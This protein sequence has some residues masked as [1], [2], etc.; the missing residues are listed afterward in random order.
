ML[1]QRLRAFVRV[2]FLIGFVLPIL[3]ASHAQSFPDVFEIVNLNASADKCEYLREGIIRINYSLNCTGGQGTENR[4][5]IL[6]L[7]DSFNFVDSLGYKPYIKY[8]SGVSPKSANY[9]FE[10]ERGFNMLKVFLYAVNNE[11][12]LIHE[13]KITCNLSP[14]LRCKI[15]RTYDFADSSFIRLIP[16]CSKRGSCEVEIINKVPEVL[17]IWYGK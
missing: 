6:A 3:W 9:T 12:N 10:N 8:P 16:E 15:N 11:S 2:S 14:T 17:D 7:N 1:N 5:L 13:T 4:Y